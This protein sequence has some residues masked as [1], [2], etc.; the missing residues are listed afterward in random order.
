MTT[1]S[2]LDEEMCGRTYYF[3]TVII[4]ISEQP[5][6]KW[7][8]DGGWRRRDKNPIYH[9]HYPLSCTLDE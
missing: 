5:A 7:G 6:I 3:F 1:N 9:Q 4:P 8:I 2:P